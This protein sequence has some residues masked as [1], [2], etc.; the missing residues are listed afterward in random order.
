MLSV[1]LALGLITM[2]LIS[3]SQE[4]ENE[5]KLSMFFKQQEL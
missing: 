3:L 4:E 2:K 5:G 1:L